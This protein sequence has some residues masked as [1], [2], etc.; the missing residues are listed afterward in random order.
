MPPR[1]FIG[2]TGRS[3]TT[4]LYEALGCHE[5]IHA[6]PDEM[7]FI[8]DPDGL[9]PLIDAL[10]VRYSPVQAREALYKFERLMRVYLTVPQRAPYKDYDLARWLGD[11]YYWRRLDQFCSGL[12]EL[13]F[14][15]VD[16]P[17]EPVGERGLPEASAARPWQAR[18][19]SDWRPG[20]AETLTLPRE[21]LNVVKYFPERSSLISSAAAFVE[22]LFLHAARRRGKQTWCEKT[23][24]NLLHV[25]FLWELFPRS[26]FIHI[27]RDPRGVVHSLV[28]QDWAPSDVAGACLFVR[29]IYER[30]FDL[31]GA[32][33][34]NEHRYLELKLE[35]VAA[36]PQASLREIASFCGLENRFRGL[37][38]IRPDK[39]NYWRETMPREDKRLVNEILGP[40]IERLGYE[41]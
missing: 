15:G 40:Y 2:G 5:A 36:S 21:Q 33:N 38:E 24:N 7:R 25:D 26:V 28:R 16:L 13:A 39:V 11:E 4:L 8:V 12:V 27:K 35:D 17:V 9:M 29:G 3:G 14:D 23:P 34:L 18:G 41:I 22:E 37:P 31:K 1:I 6:L 10:T 30:W 32:L 19:R 20:A